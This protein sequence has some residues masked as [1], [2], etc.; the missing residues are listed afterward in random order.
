MGSTDAG[1]SSQE[2]AQRL[3]AGGANELKEAKPVSAAALL[4]GQFKSLIIWVLIG[5]GVV[6]G[7]LGEGVDCAAILAIVVLNAGIGFYQEF[8]AGKSIA[9][10]K[11][12]TAPMASVRRDGQVVFDQRLPG[13][14]PATFC[15]WRRGT[16]SRPTPGCSKRPR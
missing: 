10:L 12:L 11:K 1:L 13:G 5:A 6:S 9:A 4:A 8:K 16:W 14:S 2:A 3:A 7:I 15:C